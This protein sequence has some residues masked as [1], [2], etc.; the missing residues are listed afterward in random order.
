MALFKS[1][2]GA[3]EQAASFQPESVE[4]MRRRAK[5]RLIGASVLVLIALV[6]FPLLFDTQPRPVAVDIP[7]EIPDKARV[8]P[9]PAPAAAKSAASSAAA[10]AASAAVVAAPS[11]GAAVPASASLGA[12]EEVIASSRPVDPPRP[13]EPPKPVAKPETPKPE[14]KPAEPKPAVAAAKPD[15]GAKARALLEGK[16]PEAGAE[17]RFIVQVGAFADTAKARETRQKLERAGLKTYAQVVKT[18]DGDRTRVRIGPFASRA[19]AEKAA[20]KIKGL[21]LPASILTL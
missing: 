20:G 18:K 10:P 19:E 1:R 15:D 9:L 5:H 2:K 4:V 14:A 12:K 6:G 8:K 7:I 16:E 13:V 17:G 21:E 11:P 3:D